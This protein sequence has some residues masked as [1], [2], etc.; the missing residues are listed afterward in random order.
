[1]AVAG[2]FGDGRTIIDCFLQFSPNLQRM[3]EKEE[4][5]WNALVSKLFGGF[6][7]L[8]WFNPKRPHLHHGELHYPRSYPEIDEST[9]RAWAK[10]FNLIPEEIATERG[11]WVIVADGRPEAGLYSLLATLHRR[12]VRFSNPWEPVPHQEFTFMKLFDC[13][14]EEIEDNVLASPEWFQVICKAAE[15]RILEDR[16]LTSTRRTK[17]ALADGLPAVEPR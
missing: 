10:D 8:S 5:E 6:A 14:E 3:S 2:D 16:N 4:A 15:S 7:G 13:T 12:T 11:Q 1:M 9:L 17:E